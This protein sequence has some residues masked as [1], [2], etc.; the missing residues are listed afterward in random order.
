MIFNPQ[1]STPFWLSL[2]TMAA[3]AAFLLPLSSRAQEEASRNDDASTKCKIVTNAK[4]VSIGT[5]NIL[6]TYLSPEKYN[7]LEV[8]FISHTMRD[9]PG[10]K[11]Q[12][13]IMHQGIVASADDRSGKGNLLEGIY[14]LNYALQ[15]SFRLMNDRLELH[16]GGMADLQFGAVYNSRNQNNPAQIRMSMQIGP[17]ASAKYDFPLFHK[18]W[19]A[20][21][22]L[23]LPVLGVMFSP[24]Y[25]QSYYEIFSRGNY[26]HNVVF[27]T[28][29]SAPSLRN[30]FTIDAT[31]W[32]VVLRLG[33]L[34]D[35]QQAKANSLKQHSYSHAVVI[36]VVKKL[37][38]FKL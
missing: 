24:N 10:K 15:K 34:G 23:S 29:F 3:M 19:S 32:G 17:A 25:G 31:I 38:I 2:R 30:M 33:Y 21:Y 27:T 7:G 4:M 11:W 28:P 20:R 16:V 37:K 18:P 6:D 35:F 1:S 5:T 22:E 8:R 36:G 14:N 12:Q 13:Q 26:D 9:V